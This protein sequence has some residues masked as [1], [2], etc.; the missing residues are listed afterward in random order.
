M[1]LYILFYFM[2]YI[3]DTDATIS[4][5][6]LINNS[7]S[8]NERKEFVINTTNAYGC[9]IDQASYLL[10]ECVF[11][12]INNTNMILVQNGIFRLSLCTL[13]TGDSVLTTM[14]VLKK[15]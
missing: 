9:I 5:P 6:V 7:I 11:F 3:P 1:L 10:T 12:A 13:L 8:S 4:E 14:L 15:Q 2:V